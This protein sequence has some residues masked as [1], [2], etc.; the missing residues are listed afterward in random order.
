MNLDTLIANRFRALEEYVLSLRRELHANPELSL[1]EERTCARVCAELE[2][3]GI[4]F[5]RLADGCVAGVLQGGKPGKR[6]ALRA[7][8]D[9]LPIQEENDLPWRSRNDGVMHACGHD[10]H[11]AMLLGAARLLVELRAELAGEVVLCFQAG[12]ELGGGADTLIAHLEAIGGVDRALAMHLWSEIPAGSISVMPGARMAAVDAFDIEVTGRGGHGSRPDRCIDPLKPAAEMLL[13]LSAIPANRVKAT[14]PL[15]IHIGKMEGG[16]LRNVFPQSAFLYGGIRY[17][18]SETRRAAGEQIVMIAE[19]C[20]RMHGAAAKVTFLEGAPAV[21]N[22]P[23]AVELAQ[24]VITGM[25]ALENIPFEPICASENF[26][27]F[28]QKFPGF[29]AFLGS[30]NPQW[31]E[32]RQ[33]HH[34][35]FDI[36]ESVLIR[37]TE[38]FARYAAC[39]LQAD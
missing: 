16:T 5:T 9:A 26:S 21:V 30:H 38:F 25:P 35:R 24:E 39:F 13:A 17:F 14:D 20:A 6:L 28:L 10:G 2:Q 23:A 33:H 19:H 36:D 34:P 31:G 22:D 29:M 15:V 8:M 37:G 27:Y 1:K 18:S 11:T 12:E 7:D 4:P 32:S 3:M